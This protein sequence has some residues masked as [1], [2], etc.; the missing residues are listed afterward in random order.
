MSMKMRHL[1]FKIIVHLTCQV[2]GYPLPSLVKPL[3]VNR[4]QY[5]LP[6]SHFFEVDSR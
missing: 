6:F 1:L 4:K 3:Q 5:L 2:I